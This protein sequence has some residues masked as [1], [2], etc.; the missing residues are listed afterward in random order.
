MP[1]RA[2]RWGA[3]GPCRGPH[4]E[5]ENGAM[6]LR[7]DRRTLLKGTA[8]AAAATSLPRLTTA[9]AAPVKIGYTL[10]ATGPYAV[11]AG[12]TQAPTYELWI[13]QVNAKGGLNVRGQG[14]RPIQVVRHDDRSEIETAVRLYEKM[15]SDDKV[16][17]LLPPWGT[18]MNFAVAPVANKA[19]YP[20]IG[21]TAASL[22]IAELNLP[23]FYAVLAQ[24][25]AMMA[26]LVG[27]LRDLKAKH[28]FN[29]CGVIHV[30]DV[31]DLEQHGELEQILQKGGLETVA[32]MSYPL[33]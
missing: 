20:L 32:A 12:I 31:F 30:S 13:D 1:G 33:G 16:D 4:C 11:G 22:K 6:A 17:L 27:M 9:Q 26:A 24:P 25:D 21:P 5:K 2:E 29:K 14:R 18:A 19:G 28:K 23:Y 15:V 7:L 10:S 8:A 3:W